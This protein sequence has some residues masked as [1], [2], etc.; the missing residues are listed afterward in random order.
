MIRIE[1]DTLY[2]RADLAELLAPAGVDPDTFIARLRPRKVFRCLYRGADI[3]TAYDQAAPL[4]E[5]HALPPAKNRGGRRRTARKGS[6]AKLIGN[7]FSLEELGLEE[8]N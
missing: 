2:T 5:Q 6:E 4:A 1:R 8:R 3:L 7:V